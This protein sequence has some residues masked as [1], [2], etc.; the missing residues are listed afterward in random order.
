MYWR[1]KEIS[2]QEWTGDKMEYCES[3]HIL[4]V[5]FR[6]SLLIIWNSDLLSYWFSL[7]FIM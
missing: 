5:Y 7:T 1:N 6:D 3:I 4:F 2:S